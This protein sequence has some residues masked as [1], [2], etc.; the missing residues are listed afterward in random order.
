MPCPPGALRSK[1]PG[2]K[3]HNWV[4]E[5]G[6]LPRYIERIACHL[7]F[8]KGRPI[9]ISIAIAV[10]VVKRMCATGDLNFP[11]KQNVNPKSHAEACAAVAQWEKMKASAHAKSAAKAAT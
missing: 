1:L 7:H 11:G 8:E 10:N 6:G 4:T 2:S 5:E 9:D 3:H